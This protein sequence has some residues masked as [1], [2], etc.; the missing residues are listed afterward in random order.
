MQADKI[1]VLDDGRIVAQGRHEEL[2]RT[3]PVYREI[4]ASQ[5]SEEEL[6]ATGAGADGRRGARQ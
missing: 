3:S 2:L 4:A 1:V 6:A 5:L